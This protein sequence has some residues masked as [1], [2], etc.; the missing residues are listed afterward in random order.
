VVAVQWHPEWRVEAN[1]DSQ[2]FFALMG[3]LLR[4]EKVIRR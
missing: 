4:G 2:T 3:R 1:P